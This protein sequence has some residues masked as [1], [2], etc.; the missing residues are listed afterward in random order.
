MTND[1]YRAETIRAA[2]AG[3]AEAGR[4][5]LTLC[6][7]GLEQRTLHSELADYLAARINEILDGV[8]PDRALCIARQVG[9]PKDELPEWKQHLGALAALL[10][11]R[12]YK[13]KQ[14]AVALCDQRAA[15]CDKTLEESD[16][17]KIRKAWEPMQN[18]GAEEDG[19]EMLLHLAG[20]YRKVLPEYP[21]LK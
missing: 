16:A 7:D 19:E 18:I 4:E 17:H 12:G 6:R 1:E 10:D 21:P 13:P 20:P 14:I 8:A 9:R 2:L 11:R 5:A 3:D 15:I